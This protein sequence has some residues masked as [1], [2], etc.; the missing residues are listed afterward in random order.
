MFSRLK[1]SLSVFKK[2][3]SNTVI[4]KR[5]RASDS[6]RPGSRVKFLYLI[7]GHAI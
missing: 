6:D 3:L 4:V 1:T 7:A 2:T 5:I